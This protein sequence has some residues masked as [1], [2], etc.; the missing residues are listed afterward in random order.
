MEPE[1]TETVKERKCALVAEF[2]EMHEDGY[3][4]SWCDFTLREHLL[5][6]TFCEAMV[7][8]RRTEAARH[9][10]SRTRRRR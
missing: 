2:K 1:R 6:D 8:A 4:G 10:R 3:L 9:R 5:T 7:R